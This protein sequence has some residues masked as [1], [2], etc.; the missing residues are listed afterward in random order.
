MVDDDDLALAAAV[1]E[2]AAGAFRAVE[3]PY[4]RQPFQQRGA[5]HAGLQLLDFC[6]VPTHGFLLRSGCP[7]ARVSLMFSL[8]SILPDM[9]LPAAKPARGKGVRSTGAHSATHPCGALGASGSASF[10]IGE[11]CAQPFVVPSP[12]SGLGC[13][14]EGSLPAGTKPVFGVR[15]GRLR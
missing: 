6:V 4:R 14:R 5:A 7:A 13:S 11:S 12:V 2:A 9:T 1:F 3:P 10:G 15:G 8:C